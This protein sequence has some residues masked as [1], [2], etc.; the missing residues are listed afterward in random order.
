MVETGNV[1]KEK[2]KGIEVSINIVGVK[3]VDEYFRDWIDVEFLVTKI[4]K[5]KSGESTAERG[6]FEV[7][8]ECFLVRDYNN[9]YHTKFSEFLQRFKEGVLWERK[10][11]KEEGQIWEDTQDLL[12][13]MKQVLGLP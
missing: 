2:D 6:E 7:R 11:L 4:K 12:G 9:M 3:N 5:V 10:V 8:V 1:T 13:T